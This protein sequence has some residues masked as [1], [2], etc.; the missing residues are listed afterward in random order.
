MKTISDI[1]EHRALRRENV[2]SNVVRMELFVAYNNG[3]EIVG[4]LP[5]FDPTP[6]V[7]LFIRN[8]VDAFEAEL[9]ETHLVPCQKLLGNIGA[10]LEEGRVLELENLS[11]VLRTRVIGSLEILVQNVADQS[12]TSFI[13]QKNLH[14]GDYDSGITVDIPPLARVGLS[15][16]EMTTTGFQY[17]IVPDL[18]P[19]TDYHLSPPTQLRD[20]V[21]EDISSKCPPYFS[22]MDR[23]VVRSLTMGLDVGK[24]ERV[25]AQVSAIIHSYSCQ[26]QGM[27]SSQRGSG[28]MDDV[29]FDA[30]MTMN[31]HDRRAM[32]R[33]LARLLVTCYCHNS[34]KVCLKGNIFGE[35]PVDVADDNEETISPL[36]FTNFPFVKSK[37]LQITSQLESTKFRNMGNVTSTGT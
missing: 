16:T 5:E 3:M 35:N 6:C 7:D 8:Q 32:F 11:N 34:W 13:I 14:D 30:F 2:I 15:D 10:L 33:H 26:L 21:E 17:G 20:V 22:A 37:V 1:Y 18:L 19:L 31:P 28:V 9:I 24:L 4:H 25:K 12:T 27:I 36:A 23:S 29:A